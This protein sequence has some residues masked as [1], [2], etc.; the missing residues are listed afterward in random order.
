MSEPTEFLKR[1]T[2][3][4]LTVVIIATIFGLLNIVNILTWD[5]SG[6]LFD[7]D[8]LFNM[9]NL[10]VLASPFAYAGV[11]AFALLHHPRISA[12]LLLV[13]F[14]G[15]PLWYVYAASQSYDWVSQLPIVSL[16]AF[17]PDYWTYGLLSAFEPLAIVAIVLLL[18]LPT[19]MNQQVVAGDASGATHV[20]QSAPATA[21]QTATS[22]ASFCPKCGTPAGDGDFCSNC[23]SSLMSQSVPA[24]AAY[25]GQGA[26][27][28]P[29]STLAIV[30]LIVSFFVPIVGLIL[31]YVA[32]KEIDNSSGRLSGRG[33]AT[34]AIVINWIWVG[35]LIIWGFAAA[36][37]LA[38]I[39]SY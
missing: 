21:P 37:L 10:L 16:S 24:G 39:P 19:R 30:A 17:Q 18:L 34:A 38:Q 32:R 7:S 26:A 5:F 2:G 35:S 11:V 22:K 6:G 23:G 8:A 4:T 15:Y 27:L 3:R 1:I 36:V 13:P 33:L 31:G 25:S 14:L 9:F 28:A 20:A 29:T 12:L